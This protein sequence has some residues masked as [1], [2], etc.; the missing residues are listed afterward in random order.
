V[1]H[2]RRCAHTCHHHPLHLHHRRGHAGWAPRGECLPHHHP[3]PPPPQPRPLPN[4]SPPQSTA[5]PF[6]FLLPPSPHGTS[7]PEVPSPAACKKP[8]HHRKPDARARECGGGRSSG[9]R[10]PDGVRGPGVASIALTGTAVGLPVA[11]RF[12]ASGWARA[13][14]RECPEVCR[15]EAVGE[16]RPEPPATALPAQRTPQR[17]SCLGGELSASARHLAAF[18]RLP[19]Y[20]RITP[21]SATAAVV[22]AGCLHAC[23]RCRARVCCA[24][25]PLTSG[26]IVTCVW[27]R[28]YDVRVRGGARAPPHMRL[29]RY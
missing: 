13:L 7:S 3:P 21:A 11:A 5:P 24:A 25:R 14:R 15:G 17:P 8:R 1:P 26:C 6:P 23:V 10:A 29:I 22:C 4:T 18:H 20:R 28:V 12:L 19:A 27:S 2:G 9:P 16:A